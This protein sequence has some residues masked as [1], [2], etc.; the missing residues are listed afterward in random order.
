MTKWSEALA[1]L[2][3]NG[4][5]HVIV[6]II[7]SRGSTPR[8]ISSKMIVTD[9]DCID[10]IGGGH[11][12]YQAIA[13]ARKML[14]KGTKSQAI[15]RYPLGAS[16]GQCCGGH[17]SLFFECYANKYPHLWVFG[18]GHV[19]QALMSIVTSLP[20]PIHWVDNRP[21]LLQLNQNPRI[22]IHSSDDPT[23]WLT[24]ATSGSYVLILTH[25][26]QL[27]FSLCETALKRNDFGYIGC[28]GS[29]TKAKR[30]RYRLQQKE[31]SQQQ[32][33]NLICPVGHPDIEGKLPME[34]AVSIASQLINFYQQSPQT[35]NESL[36]ETSI[37]Q[38]QKTI[39]H[40][41]SNL[42]EE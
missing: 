2:Q 28:I 18:A 11:L 7:G 24:H 27:D 15:Q 22:Q 13:Y 37:I 1:Q 9:N 29:K 25:D 21:N 33:D 4:L 41:V 35:S 36:S 3:H 5:A 23:E 39:K 16:L 12:E 26:H 17:V 38:F 31:F 19:A 20:I 42:P 30:F 10:T 8:D 6:T 32:I 14:Q 34:V 40:T